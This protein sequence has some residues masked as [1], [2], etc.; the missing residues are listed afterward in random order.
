MKLLIERE[1]MWIN[2]TATVPFAIKMYVGG[3]NAVSGF[4]MVENEK[5]KEKRLKMLDSAKSIQDYMVVPGQNWLDGIVSE[6][7]KIRQFVAK[8]KGSGF[9]VEAQVTGEEK[10]GGIQIEVIPIKRNLPST[11]DV[12]YTDRQERL[13]TR[14][15]N[16]AEKGLSAGSTWQDVKTSIRNEFDIAVQDQAL[17]SYPP[18]YGS[19]TGVHLTF[20]D[21]QKLGDC[22]FPSNFTL[23]VS[24]KPQAT[25]TDRRDRD[26]YATAY[27]AS[28]VPSPPPPAAPLMAMACFGAS[29]S[30]GPPGGSFSVASPFGSGSS[31]A[32]ASTKPSTGL[33]GSP[34]ASSGGGPFGH[35]TNV[36]S[37]GGL[38]GQSGN[39]P[40][41]GGL[42]GQSGNPPVTGSL[43][44]QAT[45]API[46][47][48]L[49]G[50]SLPPTN[51]AT[52]VSSSLF[53]S[54]GAPSSSL[55]GSTGSSSG[56]LFGNSVNPTK[57]EGGTLFGSA[58]QPAAQ[59]S[60]TSLFGSAAPTGKASFASFG[61]PVQ[62]SGETAIPNPFGKPS[63]GLFGTAPE[64]IPRSVNASTPLKQTFQRTPPNSDSIQKD[65]SEFLTSLTGAA[66]S[67]ASVTK[68]AFAPK[69]K[70][71]S[72]AA[73]RSVPSAPVPVPAPLTVK[74]MGLAAG[75]MISQT[76]IADSYPADS[77]D[78]GAAV[79]MNIQI[80]DVESFCNV[81]GQPAPTT[82]VDAKT[83]ADHGYPFFELW[84]EEKSGIKGEFSEVKSVAEIEAERAK[85][86][87]QETQR[88]E[89]V[90][91]RVIQLGRF[92]TTFR[93]LDQLKKE[94]EGLKLS[95]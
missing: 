87:G 24:H 52:A 5:T 74:E 1:A 27:S 62:S 30:I 35:L 14:T 69:M 49:F 7:G 82:P 84:G 94:L 13:L 85:A 80:L 29:Q 66:F 40:S 58:T 50:N 45:N 15:F 21:S 60:S 88:E 25:H 33:F 8:P 73:R 47:G 44:G 53:G 59:P 71:K 20:S 31:T 26:V 37:T 91:I 46:T 76:I 9:S 28:G 38:L 56:G 3:V 36:P 68:S 65:T 81:T 63:G 18:D 86:S 70:M 11:F 43:F 79:M 23:G 16:L 55:F 41:M 64:E 6:D 42:F 17:E 51:T 22:Y 93:P 95:E 61:Q 39:S 67:E 12:R 4:P 54:K 75:G 34:V 72:V 83:Y 78:I 2:F 19:K 32:P 92:K 57:T 89:S 10:V 90:P 48:G 77:W